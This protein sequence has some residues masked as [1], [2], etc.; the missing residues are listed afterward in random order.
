MIYQKLQTLVR[1]DVQVILALYLQ[2]KKRLITLDSSRL[3][4]KNKDFLFFPFDKNMLTFCQLDQRLISYFQALPPTDEP[5]KYA[6]ASS[7]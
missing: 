2:Q 6:V 3:N 7:I 5:S 1:L 4:V